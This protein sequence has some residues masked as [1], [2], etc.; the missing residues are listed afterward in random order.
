MIIDEKEWPV[1]YDAGFINERAAGVLFETLRDGLDWE[2]RDAPRLEYWTNT[3]GRPYTYG[4]G[5]G[6]RTYQPH[7]SHPAIDMVTAALRIR[8]GFEYEG[9]FLNRYDDGSKSLGW[10]ADDDPGI[11]HDYP[12]AVV[13]VGDGREI[14]FREQPTGDN[15]VVIEGVIVPKDGSHAGAARMMLGPGSLLLM[16]AGMQQTHWHRIPKAGRVVGPRISLT[17]RKLKP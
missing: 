11:D 8:L 10:H 12:I 14:M 2:Q 9:C 5:A 7:Q 1:E 3:L 17:F 4:R 13:T 15:V 16:N 6:L